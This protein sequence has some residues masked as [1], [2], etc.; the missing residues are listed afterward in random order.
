M[1]RCVCNDF[2]SVSKR[3]VWQ[4][5]LSIW[6]A[7]FKQMCHNRSHPCLMPGIHCGILGCLRQKMTTRRDISGRG[8]KMVVIVCAVREVQR[9]RLSRS[10]NLRITWDRKSLT[11]WLMSYPSRTAWLELNLQ[12]YW[13]FTVCR[14]LKMMKFQACP[15]ALLHSLWLPCSDMIT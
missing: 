9:Q 14:R 12:D 13:H 1:S 2:I 11:V 6:A 10:S 15:S 5:T 7:L 3:A 4:F 8:S